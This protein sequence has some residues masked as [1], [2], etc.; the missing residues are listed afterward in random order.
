MN[1]V[2]KGNFLGNRSS[3]PGGVLKDFLRRGVLAETCTSSFG[4]TLCLAA[5]S[6]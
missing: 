2:I 5:H 3:Q 4:L 1:I 6:T